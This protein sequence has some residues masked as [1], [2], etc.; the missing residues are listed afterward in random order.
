MQSLYCSPIEVLNYSGWVLDIEAWFMGYGS[1]RPKVPEVP[2]N[3]D[4]K[5][6]TSL[7]R[8]ILGGPGSSS[9]FSERY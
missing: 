6:V 7:D 9:V 1:Q 8:Y 2:L 3:G 5:S 4:H